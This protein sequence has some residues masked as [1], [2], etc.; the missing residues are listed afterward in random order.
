M[1]SFSVFLVVFRPISDEFFSFQIGC[2][3]CNLP[4]IMGFRRVFLFYFLFGVVKM[5]Y[6]CETHDLRRPIGGSQL[7]FVCREK[8]FPKAPL[9]F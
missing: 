2:R 3:L 1:L 7:V 6:P 5:Q 8:C 9:L 4:R